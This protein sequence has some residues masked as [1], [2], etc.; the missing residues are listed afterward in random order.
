MIFIHSFFL[1]FD[2][3]SVMRGDA[4]GGETLREDGTGGRRRGKRA[5]EAQTAR[6][7][8]AMGTAGEGEVTAL[9]FLG[10]DR[11]DAGRPLMTPPFV[12]KVSRG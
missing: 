8:E 12:S 4:T 6:S 7:M 1:L 3:Q 9:G 10:P 5:R 11:A 2:S